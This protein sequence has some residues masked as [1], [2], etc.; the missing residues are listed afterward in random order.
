M[1][2]RGVK[3]KLPTELFVPDE[4]GMIMATEHAFMST[5]TSRHVAEQFA[6]AGPSVLFEVKCRKRDAFGFHCGVD[7]SW[8]S[9][10]PGEAEVL[11]PPFT[12]FNVV[13]KRREGVKI[14]LTVVPNF[15]P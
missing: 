8:V 1:A 5:S 14:I 12:V 13:R 2:I 15:V 7:L 11:F 4:R 9:Q 10:F 6:G 3:G